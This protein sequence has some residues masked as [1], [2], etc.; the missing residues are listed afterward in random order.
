MRLESP[1]FLLL[2]IPV[3]A[4]YI[5][6]FKA[7]SEIATL[8]FPDSGVLSRVKKGATARLARI[9]DFLMI[10]SL[11]FIA[12][13]LSR[14]QVE[15]PSEFTG[16]GVDIMIAL[17]MSGSMNAIDKPL[18]EIEDIQSRGEEPKNRFEVARDV[19]RRFVYSRNED[20]LG[21]VIFSGQAFL[22]FPLTLDYSQI[23]ENLDG[24]VLDSGIKGRDGRCVNRCTI[25]GEATAIGDALARAFKR[26]ENSEAKSRNIIL[27]SDGDNNAG[28]ISPLTITNYIKDQPEEKKVRIF[29]FLVGSSENTHVPAINPFTGTYMRKRNGMLRYEQPQQPYPTNPELLRQIAELTGG[30]FYETE[31]EEEFRRAFDD[32]EKSEFRATGERKFREAFMPLAMIA[33]LLLALGCA[34]RYLFFRRFP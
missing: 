33:G 15:D 13:A 18:E 25:S 20:R 6:F 23:L 22:K 21:L 31:S 24:L 34:G 5:R 32:L 8:R 28:K 9:P 11:V 14:P 26:L 27:I 3:A 7:R 2:L 10:T 16:K 30:K 17:D 4:L 1:Y 12:A 19:L 29:T